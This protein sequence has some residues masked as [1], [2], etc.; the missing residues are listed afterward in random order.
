[1]V[2]ELMRNAAEGLV[3]ETDLYHI[4][5]GTVVHRGGFFCGGSGCGGVSAVGTYEWRKLD[6]I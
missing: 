2:C 6:G 4:F 3:Y 1:M 5:D